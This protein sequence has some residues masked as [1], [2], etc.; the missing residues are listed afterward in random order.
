MAAAVT[1]VF[2][3]VWLTRSCSPGRSWGGTGVA[4]VL[5]FGAWYFGLG[6]LTVSFFF[7]QILA[8]S[9]CLVGVG[10]VVLGVRGLPSRRW[11]PPVVVLT[12]A[13]LFTY[14]QHAVV[15]PAAV[16][17]PVAFA[18]LTRL[19]VHSWRRRVALVGSAA[20]VFLGVLA[21]SFDRLSSSPYLT[22]QAI[23]GVGE[24]FL[25]PFTVASMGGVL[26]VFLLG[27]G[28]LRLGARGVRADRGALVLLC[29]IAAPTALFVALTVLRLLGEPVTT[30]RATKN[31]YVILPL[32][33]AAAGAAVA[34]SLRRLDS[35]LQK[36]RLGLVRSETWTA[37]AGIA[38]AVLL[39]ARPTPL[40]V[41]WE[42]LVD[43]DAY[44]L[45]R[46]VV[47]R[48]QRGDVGVV[49]EGISGYVLW[50]VFFR[51][52]AMTP[53]DPIAP[54][55]TAW[56]TWPNGPRDE[57]YLLVDAASAGAFATKPGVRVVGRHN[58]ALLLERPNG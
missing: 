21:L 39:V 8:V 24:G 33:I 44:V 6:S 4:L 46:A 9:F 42:P 48:Y 52:N 58:G 30:Y 18:V 25:P 41:A 20:A 35:S 15:L 47:K 38:V 55:I 37:V 34:E 3:I 12:V 17:V 22:R 28:V 56:N 57:R 10:L 19:R 49:S 14:P 50:F 51:E 32:A 45:S 5:W 40:R 23:F 53:N 11:I 43:R 1:Q 36:L 26:G 7:S 29:A 16:V 13:T 31:V 2:G 27:A 54:P